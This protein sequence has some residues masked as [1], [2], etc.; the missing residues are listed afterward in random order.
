MAQPTLNVKTS[1]DSDLCPLDLGDILSS[2]AEFLVSDVEMC[3][4]Q[5]KDPGEDQ[6]SKTRDLFVLFWP[7]MAVYLYCK[8]Y[9]QQQKSSS[10][11]FT[12][13]WFWQTEL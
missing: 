6:I 7:P 4:A 9:S 1:T 2:R 13:P 10:F 8:E 11:Y 5:G 12:G 3:K